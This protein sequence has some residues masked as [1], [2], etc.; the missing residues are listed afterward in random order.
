MTEAG[1]DELTV[2]DGAD[3]YGTPLA[4]LSG[5]VL[6]DDVAAASGCMHLR[7]TSDGTREMSGFVVVLHAQQATCSGRQLLDGPSGRIE[8][9]SGLND[10]LPNRRCEWLVQCRAAEVLVLHFDAFVTEPQRDT[11]RLYDGANGHA[12][13]LLAE[14]SGNRHY[15]PLRSERFVTSTEAALIVFET[16]TTVQAAGFAAAYTCIVRGSSSWLA[17]STADT[18]PYTN[19][20][21]Q[22]NTDALAAVWSGVGAACGS[23][24][25]VGA[26]LFMSRSWQ[27]RRALRVHPAP[28]ESSELQKG[29]H[30]DIVPSKS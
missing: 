29:E 12:T 20:P 28:P 15:S 14:L 4:T 18:E 13:A 17:S 19:T 1:F 16:D 8:D 22:L 5:T 30:R 6:P 23:V 3:K 24:V 11:L 10:Y 7:W 26:A 27:Q 2:F 25:L 9:G 21:H